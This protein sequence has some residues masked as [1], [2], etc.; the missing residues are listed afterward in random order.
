MN[1]VPRLLGFARD[2]GL[3]RGIGTPTAVP[4]P[5]STAWMAQLAGVANAS[6][7]GRLRPLPVGTAFIAC[8]TRA[9]AVGRRE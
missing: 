4:A 6:E 2:D 8:Q 5:Q 7:G 3:R 9:C 1:V